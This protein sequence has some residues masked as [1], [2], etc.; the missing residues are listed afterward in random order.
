MQT[1]RVLGYE[2]IL[3]M[4]GRLFYLEIY[5]GYGVF[6]KQSFGLRSY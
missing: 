4:K 1:G 6:V 2:Y 3:W 5:C